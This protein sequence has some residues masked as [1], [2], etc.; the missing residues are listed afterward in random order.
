[1]FVGDDDEL[2]NNIK[3][4]SER[5]TQMEQRLSVLQTKKSKIE[6]EER[7]IASDITKKQVKVGELR[8]EKKQMDQLCS[9]RTA[10]LESLAKKYDIDMNVEDVEAALVTVENHIGAAKQSLARMKAEFD[11][12]DKKNQAAVDE[13]YRNITKMKFDIESNRKGVKEREG[14]MRNIRCELQNLS[15]SDEQFG[16]MGE[17]IKS[18]SDSLE[19]LQSSNKIAEYEAAIEEKKKMM[20]K[21]KEELEELEK[22]YK[23]LQ[24]NMI[25][26]SDIQTQKNEIHR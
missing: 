10:A 23:I 18:V 15:L 12:E 9:E 13:Q 4:F 1:M 24:Q 17:R 21:K 11:E 7:K 14:K 2:E 25:V 20:Q 16:N 8:E 19:S 5:G 22:V 6:S 26:E 3:S